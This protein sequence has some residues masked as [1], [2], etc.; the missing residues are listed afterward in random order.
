MKLRSGARLSQSTTGTMASSATCGSCGLRLSHLDFPVAKSDPGHRALA[1]CVPCLNKIN[2]DFQAIFAVRPA[3]EDEDARTRQQLR[4]DSRKRKRDDDTWVDPPE[5]TC[6]ICCEDKDSADFPLHIQRA[7][8]GS[9]LELPTR[10]QKHVGRRAEAGPV[11]KVCISRSLVADLEVKGAVGT[12]CFECRAAWD[13]K[14]V[15]LYL[16]DEP[17]RLYTDDLFKAKITMQRN[18]LWCPNKHCESGGL[19]YKRAKGGWPQVECADC[20][21]RACATCKV[22]W[23]QGLSC[24][25]A[26]AMLHYDEGERE[27]LKRL[28]SIGAKMCPRC[29]VVIEKNGGCPNM[30][31]WSSAFPRH[32]FC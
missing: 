6:R 26:K 25:L 10:C 9:R 31:C 16:A 14:Y 8:K 23:H 7:V 15:R 1:V 19:T 18:F 3:T 30:I 21:A 27:N 22:E 24:A 11:C 28:E 20:H 5:L 13:P 32:E 29:H 2:S 12:G 17:F 4:F